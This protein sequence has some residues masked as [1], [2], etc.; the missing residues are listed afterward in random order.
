[1][2]P[3]SPPLPPSPPPLPLFSRCPFTNQ[4][5][6]SCPS[7]WNHIQAQLWGLQEAPGRVPLHPLPLPPRDLY[8]PSL[9]L[10]FSYLVV[11]SLCTFELVLLWILGVLG[12]LQSTYPLPLP[13]VASLLWMPFF[14][15]P[16]WP[17]PTSTGLNFFKESICQSD[18]IVNILT[19]KPREGKYWFKSGCPT[20]DPRW[21][22]VQQLMVLLF[23][24]IAEDAYL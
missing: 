11:T 15:P 14:V 1:M 3:G 12:H 10:R 17:W 19:D 18:I 8:G 9:S 5:L 4:V 22:A 21:P 20:P 2:L 6:W 16:W 7:V 24:L 23:K 13:Q